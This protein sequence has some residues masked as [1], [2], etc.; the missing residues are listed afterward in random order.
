MDGRAIRRLLLHRWPSPLPAQ[1][2]IVR[3]ACYELVGGFR[4]ECG[5]P[6]DRDL[7]I[8]ILR[9]WDLGYIAEPL[10]RLRDAEPV[11]SFDARGAEGVWQL[12]RDHLKIDSD[13]LGTEFEGRP[14]QLWWEWKRARVRAWRQCWQRAIWALSKPHPEVCRAA[15]RAFRDA[16]FGFSARAFSALAQSAFAGAA[17]GSLLRLYRTA[18]RNG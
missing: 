15:P 5:L 2:A 16:G 11:G 1:T 3:R 7:W 17:L 4:P 10:A 6:C 12:V 13:H 14:F 8:R 18:T 9:D